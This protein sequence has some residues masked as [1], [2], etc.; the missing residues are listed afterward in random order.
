MADANIVL[1]T[2]AKLISGYGD[3]PTLNAY[4][5]FDSYDGANS[6][7][8]RVPI[9]NV[10]YREIEYVESMLGNISN[11]C[12]DN[13]LLRG[14]LE[15]KDILTVVSNMEAFINHLKNTNRYYSGKKAISK[16]YILIFGK[17]YRVNLMRYKIAKI[18]QNMNNQ[19]NQM[20]MCA[21]S[22]AQLRCVIAKWRYLLRFVRDSLYENSKFDD[23]RMNIYSENGQYKVDCFFS[24]PKSILSKFVETIKCKSPIY[25]AAYSN[26]DK[27][28]MNINISSSLSV[29]AAVI[30]TIAEYRAVNF[31]TKCQR[32]VPEILNELRRLS[33]TKP[34]LL[35]CQSNKCT[36]MFGADSDTLFVRNIWKEDSYLA[37]FSKINAMVVLGL[38]LKN[39]VCLD[40]SIKRENA[41]AEEMLG[42]SESYMKGEISRAT[43]MVNNVVIKFINSGHPESLSVLYLDDRYRQNEDMLPSIRLSTA[44]VLSIA[45]DQILLNKQ[46]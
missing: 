11:L 4:I 13:E 14:L 26:Y 27:M 10:K 34:T 17:G 31:S 2:Y 6:I 29:Y 38:P 22:R 43:T 36:S 30:S 9:F 25:L 35:L 21:K 3:L 8:E 37:L 32:M 12:V 41:D 33:N 16:L 15:N 20:E 45:I 18:L 23:F 1:T 42:K 19:Y 39:I 44:N 7:L 5:I 28:E 24:S 46:G 40:E